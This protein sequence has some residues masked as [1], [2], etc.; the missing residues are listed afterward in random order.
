[1]LLRLWNHL[2]KRRQKQ[3]IWM[4]I[5]IV[6]ASFF[7][8]ASL[9]A[10]VPFLGVLSEPEPVFQNEYLQP[11]IKFFG[12]TE[13]NQLAL[14][15]TVL[16]VSLVLLS[17]IIRLILLWTLTRLSQLAGADLSINI[18]RHTL[19]QDYSV[20]VSRNSS[21]VIN[22]I[23]TK[24]QTVSKGVFGPILNLIS[25]SVTIIGIIAV[26]LLI[27]V[28]VTLTAFIGF[29]S[30]YL[31]VMY[32]TRRNLRENSQHIAEK[33]DL[34]VKSL[35]EGLEGI[36]EVLINNNQQFYTELYRSSDLQMRRASWRNEMIYSSPRFGME[37]VGISIVAIFAYSATLNLGGID[38]FLPI[39]GAFVLGAQKLLPAIQ[40]A[41]ASYS[42]VKGSKYSLQDVITLLD[43]PLPVFDNEQSLA[44]FPY[45]N[46][47]ELKNLSFRYSE[48]SPWILKNINLEIPK[49]SV[50]GVVGTTGCGKSTLLDLIMG[51]LPPSKGEVKVD[52]V[53][54]KAH[55]KRSWQAHI[56]NVPQH[57]YLS[58]GTIE[59]N[60]A[61][62]LPSDEIDHERVL[63]AAK[64]A[65]LSDLIE[66]WGKGY[67]TLVGERGTRL[68]GGQRQRVGLARAFYKQTDVLILDEATSALDDETELA[69]MDSI[70]NFD[71]ELTVVIIAHRI[72]TLKSCD[73]IIKLSS[74]YTMQILSYEELMN[75][76]INEGDL[77]VK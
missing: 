40:K 56:S 38:Q 77:N 60:I 31:I 69:V 62:G 25:T 76:K 42:R 67:Q 75:F 18:Y 72:T 45:E 26:L 28:T 10:V 46:S 34:M 57:I 30:L 52:N 5:F 7:E 12:I 65:Q 13:A 22:G 37:G 6:V 74:D 2:S 1:M 61:F 70:E 11:F 47:I 39:L 32:L 50:V 51:L 20:H 3:F 43:Q 59:E 54:L 63:E 68:S 55:N 21:E 8:M 71:E 35:Q 23:I 53:S 19:Y 73:M 15:M 41:Y 9:G 33:S 29:G 27:N 17:A 44:Y 49:G 14:P 16:F 4:Q 58:D 24:T 66:N 64:K 36:R 48:E